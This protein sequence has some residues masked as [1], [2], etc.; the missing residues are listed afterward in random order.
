MAGPGMKKI[1]VRAQAPPRPSR[2][3]DRLAPLSPE[4]RSIL[5]PGWNM[6]GGGGDMDGNRGSVA[7]SS[8]YSQPAGGGR[9]EERRGPWM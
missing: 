5:K 9:T 3:N 2:E 8:V 4:L 6:G 1:E 7:A